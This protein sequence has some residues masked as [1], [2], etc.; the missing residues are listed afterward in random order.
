VSRSGAAAWAGPPLPLES[1]LQQLRSMQRR[2]HWITLGI[3]PGLLILV[4]GCGHARVPL[5]DLSAAASGKSSA[6]RGEYIVRS[7]AVCG[8]CHAADAKNP[9]GPLSGG[10]E[11]HD[12]RIGTAR[13]SNLTSDVE[14]GLG[15]WSEAEI[16]RAIRNG[17]RKDGR[18]LAPVMPYAWFHEMSDA[19]ALAVARYL[20]SLPPVRN[21]VKQNPSLAF[22]LGKVF[23]LRPLPAVAVAGPPPADTVRYGAYLTQHVGL[24]AD[25]HTERTG[26][27]QKA[28]KRRLFAGM[29]H[30]PK[31]FPARPSNIT[32]D[33]E[34]GI[35]KWS[36]ADF[37]RAIR[38]G[39][40][41]SGKT[42]HPF[43]P[44][45]ELKRMTDDDLHAMYEY[46]RTVPP[47]R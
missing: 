13:G 8:H 39:A 18:L 28:D 1:F 27:L 46:L 21:E 19:D 23:F 44:W 15:S 33:P 29:N 35:G 22:K 17:Q 34:A 7:V 38:T 32:P 41:P 24:C 25:C 14:T 37:V 12:W 42:L 36:E 5:P 9:D 4:L 11:F 2:S 30:P 16:V 40:Q 47:M 31:G 26:L 43:M 6:A 10:R 20:E 3:A 45:R